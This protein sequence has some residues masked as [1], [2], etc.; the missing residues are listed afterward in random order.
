MFGMSGTEMIIIAV[1]A[2]MLLGENELPKAAKTIGKTL[3]DLKK[4]GED[5]RETFER[6]IMEEPQKPKAP[7]QGAV[8]KGPDEVRSTEGQPAQ[9]TSGPVDA[10]QANRAPLALAPASTEAVSQ[11]VPKAASGE[12]P[13]A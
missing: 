7:P 12:R 13:Q 11:D 8:A 6:E 2:L 5:L 9:L 10:T 1:L 4:A 3:R